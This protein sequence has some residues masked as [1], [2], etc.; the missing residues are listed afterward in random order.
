MRRNGDRG[1]LIL[2]INGELAPAAVWATLLR[3]AKRNK[4]TLVI[5]NES[6]PQRA[7]NI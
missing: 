1:T 5:M 4:V 2:A 6:V 7:R 3:V